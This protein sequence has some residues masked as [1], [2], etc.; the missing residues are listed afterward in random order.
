ML[1]TTWSEL[2]R[3]IEMRKGFIEDERN[4]IN[5]LTAGDANLVWLNI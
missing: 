1:P 2:S 3:A 5:P 4:V